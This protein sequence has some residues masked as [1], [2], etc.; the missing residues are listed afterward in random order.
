MALPYW[1]S[2]WPFLL[3]S[4][5]TKRHSDFVFVLLGNTRWRQIRWGSMYV[6]IRYIGVIISG[7]L[8]GIGGAIYSQTMTNDFGHATING[9]GFM[10][11]A[12]MIFGKWHPIGAMGAAL[13][14]GF[15]QALAI[16]APAIPFLANVPTVYLHIL[17]YVL[18]I[19][20]LQD[21][22]VGRLHQKQVVNHILKEIDNTLKLP[23]TSSNW[24]F[25]QL[26]IH[27]PA[28]F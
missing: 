22:S 19:L 6:K 4:S 24:D 10:A 15:A 3:G 21:L 7:G 23:C 18:T 26:F 16:S 25:R 9:Q 5:F 20:R 2:V 14:F 1:Q 8:A 27:K 13:F 28:V 11:L 17:P 12:A